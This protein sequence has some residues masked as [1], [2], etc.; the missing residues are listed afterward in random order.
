MILMKYL[1]RMKWVWLFLVLVACEAGEKKITK[2]PAPNIPAA[3]APEILRDGKDAIQVRL[4]AT[5]EAL[6]E[7]ELVRST[8]LALALRSAKRIKGDTA[9]VVIHLTGATE[10]GLFTQVHETLEQLLLEERDSVALLRFESRYEALNDTQ[11]AVI[12]RKHHMR[13]I[14]RMKR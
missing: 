9:T 10:F 8:G 14:E 13:V 3:P 4:G 12:K 11:Q 2:Q 1:A 7:G 5:D 6:I